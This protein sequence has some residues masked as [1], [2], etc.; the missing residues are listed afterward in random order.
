MAVVEK[1]GY[2][3]NSKIPK[4]MYKKDEQGKIIKD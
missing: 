3:F 1:V 2:D 4:V